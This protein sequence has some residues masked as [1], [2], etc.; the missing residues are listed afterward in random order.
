MKGHK[1]AKDPS[2]RMK[3]RWLMQN[4]ELYSKRKKFNPQHS[5]QHGFTQELT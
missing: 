3:I 5:T 2:N 4:Y 1:I